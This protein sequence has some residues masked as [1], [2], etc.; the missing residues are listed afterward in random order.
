MNADLVG[1]RMAV[2]RLKVP[3]DRELFGQLRQVEFELDVVGHDQRRKLVVALVRGQKLVRTGHELFS[4][5]VLGVLVDDGTDALPIKFACR[6]QLGLDPLRH[7]CEG[8][9]L[10][11]LEVLL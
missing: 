2:V 11:F 6:F 5:E 8:L 7:L 3:S 1:E 4:L 10:S 9:E